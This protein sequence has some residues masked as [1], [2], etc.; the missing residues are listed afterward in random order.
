MTVARCLVDLLLEAESPQ[1]FFR[2]LGPPDV[3]RLIAF[4]PKLPAHALAHA[5]AAGVVFSVEHYP[6]E[7]LPDF[8]AATNNWIFQQLANGNTWGWCRVEVHARWQ[9]AEGRQYDGVSHLGGCGY[10]N[11]EDFEAPGGYYPQML[12]EALIDL[13]ENIRDGKTL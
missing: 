1:Q 6:E 11:Q 8:D 7:D 13:L 2:R 9:D 5:R 10:A 12:E 3:R 4:L